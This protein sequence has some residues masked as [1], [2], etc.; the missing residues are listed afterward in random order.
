MCDPDLRLRGSVCGLATG[1]L[2]LYIRE[3]YGASMDRLVTYSEIAPRG[4]NFRRASHVVL[5]DDGE[6]FDPTYSQFF[7][8]VGLTPEYA[9]SS[10]QISRLYPNDPLAIF[11]SNNAG[12]FADAI[13]LRAHEI[14]SLLPAASEGGDPAVGALRS[15]TVEEKQIVYRDLWNPQNYDTLPINDQ[16]SLCRRAENV[17]RRMVQLAVGG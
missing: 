2:Q 16:P 10:E 11:Q 5:A 3:M 8:Y 12:Q 1:A 7:K 13:A 4:Y 17:M 14:E 9:Q 15:A 6:F